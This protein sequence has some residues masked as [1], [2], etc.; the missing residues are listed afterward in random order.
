MNG[1]INA[2]INPKIYEISTKREDKWPTVGR[3]FQFMPIE[4]DRYIHKESARALANLTAEVSLARNYHC[5]WDLLAACPS[6][7][8][9]RQQGPE[10]APVQGLSDP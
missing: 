8:R 1:I 10:L 6:V 7:H 9:R 4:P 3:A 5:L 2:D